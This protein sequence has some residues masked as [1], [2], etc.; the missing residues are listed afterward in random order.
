M[1]FKEKRKQSKICDISFENLSF[2][3]FFEFCSFFLSEVLYLHYIFFMLGVDE[4]SSFIDI[5][6]KWSWFKCSKLWMFQRR[7]QSA[8]WI[9][10]R[11][12]TVSY[13]FIL[14]SS[15]R[16]QAYAKKFGPMI[17]TSRKQLE[18][19]RYCCWTSKLLK[20]LHPVRSNFWLIFLESHSYVQ[21][22]RIWL[23]SYWVVAESKL[24]H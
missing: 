16:W 6:S 18:L 9:D 7:L 20:P 23:P 1:P 21:F 13:P 11:D 19:R 2:C 14:Y 17:L 12:S 10:S 8:Y 5:V 22:F 24:F 15:L 3:S 4:E